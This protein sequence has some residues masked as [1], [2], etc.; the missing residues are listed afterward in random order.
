MSMASSLFAI[1][2]SGLTMS[3][4]AL[5]QVNII[6]P[7]DRAEIEKFSALDP[8]EVEM[9]YAN[10]G[11]ISCY[12]DK[13][14]AAA[15]AILVEGRYIVTNAHAMIHDGHV[16]SNCTFALKRQAGP[17]IRVAT[18]AVTLGTREPHVKGNGTND[19]AIARLA[20]PIQTK[21]KLAF[22]YSAPVVGDSLVLV[23]AVNN[24][25][26]LDGTKL[27]GRRCGVRDSLPPA[28]KDQ[29]AFT[30]DCDAVAGDS[31]GAYFIRKGG[32]L[33]VAGLHVMGGFRTRDG[34]PYNG[35]A[36]KL[37]ASGALALDGP[38]GAAI[39]N[40]THSFAQ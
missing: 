35:D 26:R 10:I 9:L 25:E 3:G 21:Q 18:N 20:K 34:M 13:R 27:I 11:Q 17:P 23:T 14:G 39:A 8:D 15:T 33:N 19:W 36:D 37:S 4:T 6:G 2:V 30:N 40:L 5:Q 38:L 24:A 7:D 1:G 28:G 12:F 16:S 31:G 32:K 22:S 29:T